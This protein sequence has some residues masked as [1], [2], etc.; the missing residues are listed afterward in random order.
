MRLSVLE[1]ICFTLL[2]AFAVGASLAAEV[3]ERSELAAVNSRDLD[4]VKLR[5]GVD[6]TAYKSVLID[7][8]RVEFHPG[9]TRNMITQ[10]TATHRLSTQDARRIAED[11]SASLERSLAA[12]FRGRGYSIATSPGPNVLRLSAAVSDLYVNAPEALVSGGGG[13]YLITREAG[14]AV[15]R[16]QVHDAATAALLATVEHHGYARSVNR[17][18][19]THDVT[20]RYSFDTLFDRWAKDCATQLAPPPGQTLSRLELD[21]TPAPTD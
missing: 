8:P 16:L 13:G 5:P 20:T 17:L 18:T 6:F 19:R 3:A 10:R 1:T 15:L 9:W 21:P 2:A 14:D 12:A 4:E 7:H 11:F